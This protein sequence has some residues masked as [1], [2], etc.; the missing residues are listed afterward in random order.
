MKYFILIFIISL[1]FIGCSKK[2]SNEYMSEAEIHLKENNIPEAVLAYETVVN[3]FPESEE[4][5]EALYQLASLYQ[6][7]MIKNL[8]EHESL[9][10]SAS[11][12]RSLYEKYP[13]SERAPMALFMTAFIQANDLKK[14]N[15][16]SV[17]YN[18]FLEKYPQH[19]LAASAKEELEYMGLTPEEILE[20]KKLA[21]DI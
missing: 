17:S 3:D 8:S 14:Y 16:A 4:A 13:K 11:T 9:E 18:L 21:R 6:N 7:K 5:P 2:P 15:E 1:A 20:K 10:R 19:S 12:F